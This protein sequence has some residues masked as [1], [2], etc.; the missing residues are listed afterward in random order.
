MGGVGRY[1]ASP[2]AFLEGSSVLADRVVLKK[3]ALPN[4]T[5]MGFPLP[6]RYRGG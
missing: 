4:G 5:Y 2:S 3:R 1:G 6:R